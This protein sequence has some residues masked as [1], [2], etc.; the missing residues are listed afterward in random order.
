MRDKQKVNLTVDFMTTY[1]LLIYSQMQ[2]YY[3]LTIHF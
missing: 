1:V 3:A 2:I